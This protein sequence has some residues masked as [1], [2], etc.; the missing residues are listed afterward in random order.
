[1]DTG[2][3]DDG[4][5]HLERMDGQPPP[6]ADTVEAPVTC[7]P[8]LT[9]QLFS[10]QLRQVAKD[11]VSDKISNTSSRRAA[12]KLARARLKYAEEEAK[13]RRKQIEL[14]LEMD[15]LRQRREV[16]MLAAKMDDSSS[17]KL[18][19]LEIPHEDKI[20]S[21]QNY[22]NSIQATQRRKHPEGTLIHNDTIARYLAKRTFS[23]NV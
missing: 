1:M 15:L 22:V 7:E 19:D 3:K 10:T 11:D 20:R 5:P 16:A 6:D 18:S 8:S 12:L 21:T 14:D 23:K 2:S 17:E 4:P 9:P 13:L